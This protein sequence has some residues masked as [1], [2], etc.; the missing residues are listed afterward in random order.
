MS[1][2]A[3]LVGVMHVALALPPPLR[4]ETR[5]VG[6]TTTATNNGA[7]GKDF[8]LTNDLLVSSSKTLNSTSGTSA[9]NAKTATGSTSATTSTKQNRQS[10]TLGSTSGV[11]ALNAKT[12]TGSTSASTSKKQSKQPQ[13]YDF[14]SLTLMCDDEKEF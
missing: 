1:A 2:L 3:L 6:S 10:Q 11:S 5:Q 14:R 13:R 8:T 4:F 7:T 12:A 9:L